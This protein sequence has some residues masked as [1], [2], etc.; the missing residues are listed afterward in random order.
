M[1]FNGCFKTCSLP[2][3]KSLTLVGLASNGIQWMLQNLLT[4]TLKIAHFGRAREQWYSMDASKPAHYHAQKRSLWSGSRAMVF[5]GCFKTCSLPRSKSLTLVGL[6]SNGIQW[7]LQNLL[8]T[9]LKIAHFGRARE[10]WYSMDAS[11][12][13]HCH[14]QNRSL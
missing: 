10:Q 12:P 14:A 6:A 9:T 2:R 8:T 7:M 5:N 4:T 3:S 13:A 11:K 1:V